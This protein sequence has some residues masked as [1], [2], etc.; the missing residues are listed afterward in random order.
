MKAIL[1]PEEEIKID[2]H[3]KENH[4]HFWRFMRLFYDCQARTTEMMQ[5]RKNDRVRID[6]QEIIV[7][8]KKGSEVKDDSRIIS[9]E[10][11][12]LWK[13]VWSEAK[14]GQFLFS[15]NLKPGD[16]SIRADQVGRRWAKYVKAKKTG[17]G[18]NKDFYSLK[19]LS[20]DKMSA[21]YGL[22]V[23]SIGAGHTNTGTT[24]KYYTVG[25]VNREKEIL[26]QKVVRFGG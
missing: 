9:K 25:Q 16:K 22:K 24:R 18:I 12:Y 3:L 15:K 26:K 23:A 13:E 10:M 7:T 14:P 11:I 21:D 8:V 5:L 2:K 20:T 19:H 6:Q 17:L 4:Y 1:T